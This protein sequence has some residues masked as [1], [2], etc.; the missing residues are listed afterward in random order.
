MSET[1]ELKPCPFCGGKAELNVRGYSVAAY[2]M[3]CQTDGPFC[4]R[5][6][7]DRAIELW[8]TRPIET[9]LQE[10][11]A[12]LREPTPGMLQEFSLEFDDSASDSLEFASE[13]WK[14][15]VKIALKEEGS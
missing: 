3:K 7:R 11:N 2:C 5:E 4:Y 10:E 14:V 12:T 13:L 6:K 9:A 8:N 15:M 1:T